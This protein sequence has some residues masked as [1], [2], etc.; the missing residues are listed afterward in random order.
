MYNMLKRECKEAR[1]KNEIEK[2]RKRK[3]DSTFLNNCLNSF[4]NGYY[5]KRQKHIKGLKG[6]N[7]W[8]SRATMGLK[9]VPYQIF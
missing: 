9:T 4:H 7:N 2:E 5:F 1:E 8:S 3:R 6:Q